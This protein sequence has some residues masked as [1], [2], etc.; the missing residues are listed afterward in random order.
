MQI[1][2][3]LLYHW[4]YNLFALLIPCWGAICFWTYATCKI[5]YKLN[6]DKVTL[7]EKLYVIKAFI[8]NNFS[9]KP[10]EVIVHYQN[11]YKVEE[12]FKIST[13]GLRIRP[14]ERSDNPAGTRTIYH[15]LEN[16][17]KAHILISFVYREF[18]RRLKEKGIKVDFSQK[19]LRKVIEH[20]LA[21]EL[22]RELIPINPSK[23][24]RQIL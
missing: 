8:T 18:E 19:F 16:R 11:Q 4:T 9:L 5:K 15:R 23:I 20:F 10:N 3:T 12:A 22:D 24:Q 7:D 13:T 2:Q 17:I 21:I 1:L 14:S 6:Q